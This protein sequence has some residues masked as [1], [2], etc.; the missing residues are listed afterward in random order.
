MNIQD[1]QSILAQ[2]NKQV[3]GDE[4][5]SGE[6]FIT[7]AQRTAGWIGRPGATE[8]EFEQLERRLLCKL[9]PSYRSFLA[10]SNG[11]GPISCFIYNLRSVDEVNWLVNE[12]PELVEMWEEDPTPMD[13]P[14]LTDEQYLRYDD[15]QSTGVLKPAHMRQCL[16]ISDWGDAGFL[17]LNPA[18]Q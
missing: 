4:N 14:E 2:V 17:A 18:Q 10:T 7:K 3:L 5:F 9:L 6:Y 8:A 15:Q 11:F 13:I 12:E 16:M 1:W